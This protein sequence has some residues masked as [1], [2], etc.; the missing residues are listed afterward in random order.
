M[1]EEIRVAAEESGL[2]R[3]HTPITGMHCRVTGESPTL[4]FSAIFSTGKEM[5]VSFENGGTRAREPMEPPVGYGLK[6]RSI[7]RSPAYAGATG[8]SRTR[9]NEIGLGFIPGCEPLDQ[10]RHG[11]DRQRGI[12]DQIPAKGIAQSRMSLQTRK[13]VYFRTIS[14]NRR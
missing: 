8:F 11:H 14:R 13:Q 3:G 12:E 6:H 7:F 10:C 2:F 4:R 9:G 1:L 5:G